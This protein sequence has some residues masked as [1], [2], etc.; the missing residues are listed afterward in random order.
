MKRFILGIS[1][2]MLVTV[3]MMIINKIL[4]YTIEIQI[5]MYT[6]GFFACIGMYWFY[7]IHDKIKNESK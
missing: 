2:A 1:G 3:I 7:E 4:L 6:I 5:P